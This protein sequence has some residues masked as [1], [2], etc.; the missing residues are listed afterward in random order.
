MTMPSLSNDSRT[1]K[2]LSH[3]DQLREAIQEKLLDQAVQHLEELEEH[4]HEWQREQH[5]Q[6]A[7]NWL[8]AA[9]QEDILVF[10]GDLANQHLERWQAALE[11]EATSLELDQLRERVEKTIKQKQTLLV[12]RGIIAHCDEFISKANELERGAEPPHPN[13]LIENYY[14]KAKQVA[15]S[16][17][18]DYKDNAEIDVLVQ[19]T[20]RTLDQKIACGK[21]YQTALEQE[22]YR[23]AITELDNLPISFLIPHFSVKSDSAGI[24]Q[25]AFLGMRTQPEAKEE[26]TLSAQSWAAGKAV[27]MQETAQRYVD[28]H[29]PGL[30]IEAL[31]E[32]PAIQPFLTTESSTTLSELNNIAKSDLEKYEQA[33]THAQQAIDAATENPKQAWNSYATAY[34][35]YQWIPSLNRA[36]EVVIAALLEQLKQQVSQAEETFNNRNMEQVRT[37]VKKTQTDFS[38]KDPSLDELL[39]RLTELE[40]MTHQ[41]DQYIA[42]ASTILREVKETIWEDPTAANDLLSQVE[43]FP[44]IVLESFPEVYD[45]RDQVNRRLNAD[46][47]YKNLYNILFSTE[48]DEVFASIEEAQNAAEEFSNDSR[49][50]TLHKALQFHMAFLSAQQEYANGNTQKAL[51]LLTPIATAN[52]HPD[53][54][55]AARLIRDINAE[56][57]GEE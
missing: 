35:T 17:Q 9:L 56:D 18:A 49:F 2:A 19:R 15:E 36:R 3:V 12:V 14:A 55:N 48:K 51:Q 31:E 46:F 8:N 24:K 23:E 5:V 43:G 29:N 34:H 33:E 20:T 21:I 52:N 53:Q 10:N 6:N 13:F 57:E 11:D 45:L 44:D 50:N 7:R 40:E 4:L 25:L 30:A 47:T 26:L 32:L 37:I 42:D 39:A 28:N 54:E 38:Q 16:A 22:K 41:Y 27:S 1:E